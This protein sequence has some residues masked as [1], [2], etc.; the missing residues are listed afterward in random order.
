MI[1]FLHESSRSMIKIGHAIVA[2]TNGHIDV[3]KYIHYNV[4][5]VSTKCINEWGITMIRA[6][7]L[8]HLEILKWLHENDADVT[9]SGYLFPCNSLCVAIEN[10]RPD[11]IEYLIE[12]GVR[13]SNGAI[14]L[15]ADMGDLQL[16]KYLHTHG[17]R[18]TTS[19][20]YWALCDACF[21]GRLDI[22]KYL[23]EA[24]VDIQWNNSQAMIDACTYGQLDVVKYLH[25]AGANIYAIENEEIEIMYKSG[26]FDTLKYLCK[27]G[28]DIFNGGDHWNIFI[29]SA[30]HGNIEELKYICEREG[31]SFI[32][33]IPLALKF[34]KNNHHHGVVAFIK[35]FYH[36]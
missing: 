23:H 28:L 33:D 32:S 2:A 19:G 18:I 29:V 17:G 8:G 5:P 13:I 3:V 31:D 4:S 34:A 26:H 9:E 10:K 27:L 20:S 6:I 35:E 24:G 14:S 30:Y 11:V 22:V 16:L 7:M 15:A 36:L 1:K 12:S 25:E 21:R